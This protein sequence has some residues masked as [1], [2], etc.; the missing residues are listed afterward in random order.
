MLAEQAVKHDAD[1]FFGGKAPTRHV[2]D[3]SHKPIGRRFRAIGFLAQLHSP[4]V[5]M[6]QKSSPPQPRQI[7]S[8]ALTPDNYGIEFPVTDF[9]PGFDMQGAVGN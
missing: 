1:L 4:K 5:A 6:S 2:A 3:L 8:K 7:V 9:M